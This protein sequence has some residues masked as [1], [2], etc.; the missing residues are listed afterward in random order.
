MGDDLCQD[1]DDGAVIDHLAPSAS[2]DDCAW[3]QPERQATH[4]QF[5]AQLQPHAE[6]IKGQEGSP[7]KQISSLLDPVL[8]DS[9][10]TPG[11]KC[12]LKRQEDGDRKRNELRAATGLHGVRSNA[13]VTNRLADACL[14][15]GVRA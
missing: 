5:E 10:N 7:Y 15:A 9:S 6:G 14:L 3:W 4:Y 8:Q 12:A 13:T 2:L 11:C 1:A